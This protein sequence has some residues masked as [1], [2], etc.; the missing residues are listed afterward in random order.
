MTPSMPSMYAIISAFRTYA[1]GVFDSNAEFLVE[2]CDTLSEYETR[3]GHEAD[4]LRRVIGRNIQVSRD[5]EGSAQP[6]GGAQLSGLY[7]QIIGDAVDLRT[8]VRGATDYVRIEGFSET[9][10][11]RDY[12]LR[13]DISPHLQAFLQDRIHKWGAEFQSRGGPLVD[14]KKSAIAGADRAEVKLHAVVTPEFDAG[15]GRAEAAIITKKEMIRKLPPASSDKILARIN[16]ADAFLTQCI[17]WL[18]SEL[19]DGKKTKQEVEA[20]LCQTSREWAWDVFVAILREWAEIGIPPDDFDAIANGQ[21]VSL[22]THAEERVAGFVSGFHLSSG[23]VLRC[24]REFLPGL[25][26]PYREENRFRF[27]AVTIGSETAAPSV[28]A[29]PQ[30]SKAATRAERREDSAARGGATAESTFPV[31]ASWLKARLLERGWSNSDPAEYDGPDRKT[32]Q[33]ILRGESVRND[34]LQKLADALSQRHG[35]VNVLEIPQD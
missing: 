3:L 7:Q 28:L 29:T 30:A 10:H 12:Y 4:G 8:C 24:V 5:A 21:V 35:K 2:E 34:V 18:P 11:P 33:K 14:G 25:I 27:H 26:A 23:E 9:E 31:R 16:R 22:S 1:Q 20:I 19:Q 6:I 15:A 32:I 17:K 13:K